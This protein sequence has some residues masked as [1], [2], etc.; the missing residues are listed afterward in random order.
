MRMKYQQVLKY[1]ITS[2]LVIGA[3]TSMA[4]VTL[5]VA[6]CSAKDFVLGSE[7]NQIN[8]S[9]SQYSPKCLKVRTGSAVTIQASTHHPLFAMPNIDN[10]ENPFASTALFVSPQ[11]RRLVTPGLYGYFCDAHGDAEGD[12]MAGAIWVVE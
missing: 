8:T 10:V 11:T 9:G 3:Q 5:T 2:L 7:S 1:A 4:Q 6:G 12:G